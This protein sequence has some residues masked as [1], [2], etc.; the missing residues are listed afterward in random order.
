MDENVYVTAGTGENTK[1]S[2]ER[3]EWIES[4]QST[5]DICALLHGCS[6]D[7]CQDILVWNKMSD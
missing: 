3:L 5:I 1:E 7:S 6:L 4:L 2:P